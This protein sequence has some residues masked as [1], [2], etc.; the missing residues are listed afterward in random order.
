MIEYVEVPH[1]EFPEQTLLR[2]VAMRLLHH[3]N[4][5]DGHKCVREKVGEN[6]RETNCKRKRHKEL[7]SETGHE[8]RRN[9][10][11]ENAKHR[12]GSRYYCLPACLD[13][14]LGSGCTRKEPTMDVFHSNSGFVNQDPHRECQAAQCHDVDRLVCE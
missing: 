11:R 14:G 13:N 2:F 8:E 4:G 10:Y 6:H 9:E 5:A 7:L 3:P 12:K 1:T